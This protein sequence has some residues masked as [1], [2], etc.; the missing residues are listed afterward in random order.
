MTRFYVTMTWDDWPEGGSY[1]DIIE[2]PDHASAE[3]ACRMQMAE[4]QHD[5][6]E[7]TVTEYMEVYAKDWHTVDCFDLDKFI[8]RHRLNAKGE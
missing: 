2:A 7:E 4:I 3:K 5:K 8:E 6:S 1:G